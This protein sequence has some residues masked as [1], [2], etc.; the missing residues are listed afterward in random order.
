[1]ATSLQSLDDEAKQEFSDTTGFKIVT[2]LLQIVTT[3]SDERRIPCHYGGLLESNLYKEQV[4]MQKYVDKIMRRLKDLPNQEWLLRHVATSPQSVDD[5]AK[6]E[7][8]DAN[9]FKIVTD[10]LQIVTTASDERRITCHYGG[11]LES[12]LY[13]EQADELTKR[14][15]LFFRLTWVPKDFY[16][17]LLHS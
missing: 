7:F 3:A 9:G 11:L 5:E 16:R 14:P 6:Q 15:F 1:M 8:S 10:L 2:D 13:K 4:F 17:V 12:N